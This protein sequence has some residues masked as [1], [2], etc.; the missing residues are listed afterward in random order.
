MYADSISPAMAAAISETE[1]RRGIQEAYNSAH[2]ITPT[3]IE[4]AVRSAIE[5]TQKVEEDIDS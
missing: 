1:R 3:S 4:K 2:G 5:V